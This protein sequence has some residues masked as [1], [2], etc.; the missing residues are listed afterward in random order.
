VNVLWEENGISGIADWINA[1]MGP[2]GIDVAHCWTQ[3]P[4][5]R[6]MISV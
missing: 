4:M 5:G 6:G 1:C 3:D 2:I